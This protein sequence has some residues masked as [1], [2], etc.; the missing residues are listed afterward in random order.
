MFS[1]MNKY[2]VK[3]SPQ[4]LRHARAD[5][6]GILSKGFPNGHFV[7]V[8]GVFS[9]HQLKRMKAVEFLA[10]LAILLIEGPQDK[11]PA[12]DL[13]YGRRIKHIA[14]GSS[15]ETRLRQYLIRSNGAAK[16]LDTRYRNQSI[17]TL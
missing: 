13:Y 4:E 7:D 6:L 14:L 11:K 5:N 3:L 15:I 1:R 10:E 9:K 17:C 12:V 2:V 8:N 16:V